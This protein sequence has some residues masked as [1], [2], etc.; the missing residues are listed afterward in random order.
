ML[1]DKPVGGSLDSSAD[2]DSIRSNIA[3]SSPGPPRSTSSESSEIKSQ[4]SKA[5]S[6][7]EA[8][9]HVGKANQDPV[10]AEK[11]KKEEILQEKERDF[12]VKHIGLV[13]VLLWIS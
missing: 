5:Q 3:G 13:G 1:P 7:A 11:A 9:K 10:R 6:T 12:K 8:H 2:P 4:W